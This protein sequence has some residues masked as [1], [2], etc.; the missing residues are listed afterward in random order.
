[1]KTNFD[2]SGDV[3]IVTGGARG[4]GA[5][6]SRAFAEA[7]GTAV[8]FDLLEPEDDVSGREFRRVDVA[9]R[10]AV[11][12]AAAAVAGKHGRIDGL[13]AGAAVQPRVAVTDTAEETWRHTLAV[14]LDGV[15]WACQ[16]V[17]PTM[18]AAR[19]GSI[20]MFSSGLANFGRAQAAAYAAGKGALVPYAKSL[21]AEV[22]EQRVRV[23]VIFPGVIDTPQ[24]QAANP[25]GP[26]RDHWA[27]TT[28]I[29]VPG[30][31]VGPLLFLLSD[32]ATMTGSVLTRDRVFAKEND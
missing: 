15:V 3:L 5:A 11:L 12:D 18:L 27:K 31:V 28:G 20:V 29:G 13:V 19:R 14:N 22:A 26:E 8:V 23:N 24:F 7:G 17:L 1:V 32:A 21:A 9:D 6:V 4:I 10:R 25:T 30:D 16:A 2:A